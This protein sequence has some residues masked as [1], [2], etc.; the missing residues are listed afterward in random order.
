VQTLFRCLLYLY[1]ADFCREFS[2]EMMW[3]FSQSRRDV[4]QQAFWSRALFLSREISGLLAGAM[5]E[6]LSGWDS[7]RR[8]N[9]RPFRFPRSAILLMLVILFSVFVAIEKGRD[10]FSPGHPVE[11]AW[12][13][14]PMVLGALLL[15][16]LVIGAI[17]YAILCLLRQSGV[18]R[19]SN[20]QPWTRMK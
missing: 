8:L 5:R 3:V 11:P 17:G 6:R 10:V 7:T 19:L 1:P 15:V 16:M 2:D 9:M 4:R 14:M 18:E 20:V 13:V 12:L